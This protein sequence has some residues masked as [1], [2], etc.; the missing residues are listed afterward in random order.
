MNNNIKSRS[1]SIGSERFD[2]YADFAASLI[3]LSSAPVPVPS[4]EPSTPQS[5]VYLSTESQAAVELLSL[6]PSPPRAVPS[7][8]GTYLK[9]KAD[10]S[11]DFKTDDSIEVPDSLARGR[12]K[13]V[14]ARKPKD[15][16]IAPSISSTTSTALV[17]QDTA[18]I[19]SK[20]R[21][22]NDTSGG[23][24]TAAPRF[25]ASLSV[26]TKKFVEI[27]KRVTT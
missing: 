17:T 8:R 22:I 19:S 9:R 21:D 14:Y 3:E 5:P 25:L 12:K 26:L 27:L 20:Q 15:M 13:R 7:K 10:K 18:D 6:S 16:D 4:G 2:V 24:L 1:V 23:P 11:L